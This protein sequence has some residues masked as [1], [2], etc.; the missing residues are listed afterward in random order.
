MPIF[1]ATL[2]AQLMRDE[3]AGGTSLGAILLFLKSGTGSQGFSQ[4]ESE[5]GS[6]LLAMAITGKFIPIAIPNR[7]YTVQV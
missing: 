1:S 3:K 6:V 7:S 5:Q 2:C 4:V